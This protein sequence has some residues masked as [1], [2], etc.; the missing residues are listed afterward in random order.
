VLPQ[1]EIINRGTATMQAYT[2]NAEDYTGRELTV[3]IG[4]E[5]FNSVLG[6]GSYSSRDGVTTVSIDASEYKVYELPGNLYYCH[7]MDYS[8][9]S[10]IHPVIAALKMAHF[11]G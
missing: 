11:I 3:K 9:D 6:R 1:L 5:T 10:A 8:R 4:K 2:Y 7:D